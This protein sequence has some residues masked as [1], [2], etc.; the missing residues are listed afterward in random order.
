MKASGQ[1]DQ[2]SLLSFIVT[3]EPTRVL[4]GSNTNLPPWLDHFLTQTQ[5]KHEYK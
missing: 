3:T 2:R 4:T 5:A 1:E